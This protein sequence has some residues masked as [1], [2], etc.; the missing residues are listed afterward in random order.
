MEC[1]DGPIGNW[2]EKRVEKTSNRANEAPIW[3]EVL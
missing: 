1:E 2:A 3:T